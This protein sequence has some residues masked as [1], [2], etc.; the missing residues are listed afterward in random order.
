MSATNLLA[1]DHID[2]GRFGAWLTQTRD[3]LRGRGGM[4]VPCGDCVGCCTSHYSILLRPHDTA[5]DVVPTAL[6]SSVPGMWYPHAQMKPLN[7]GHCPMFQQGR[8]SIYAR[9]PQTCLD[10]D[11]RVF[12]ATGLTAGEDKPVINRR[13]R[14]WQFSYE[15]DAARRQHAATRAA[16]DFLRAHPHEFP[17][18]WLPKSPLG[19]AGLAIKVYELFVEPDGV[20]NAKRLAAAIM[21]TS[22]AFDANTAA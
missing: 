8:C 4:Q 15:D 10:Y 16:A 18:G 2:A 5:L 21:A 22:K 12:A 11:C 1:P 13:I 9:R 20:P 6:Q 19:L 17:D 14:A 7:N 3:A